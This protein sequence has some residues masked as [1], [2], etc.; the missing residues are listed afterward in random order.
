MAEGREKRE[1][2]S[3]PVVAVGAVVIHDGKLLMVRRGLPPAAGLWSIPGGRVELGETLKEAVEREIL[4]ETGLVVRAQEPV[5]SFEIIDRSAEGK[6]RFHYVIID[7]AADLAGGVLQNQGGDDAREARWV[8]GGEIAS[9]KM[10]EMTKEL[11][12]K[13]FPDFWNGEQRF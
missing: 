5:F 1:Y 8:S 11:L 2:P 13:K 9:L 10:S 7:L 4:E 6:V 3:L 12:R